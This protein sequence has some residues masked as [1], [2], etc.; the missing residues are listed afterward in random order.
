MVGKRLRGHCDS[1]SLHVRDLVDVSGQ[2]VDVNL[3]RNSRGRAGDVQDICKRQPSIVLRDISVIRVSTIPR[4][5]NRILRRGDRCLEG[6][7]WHVVF[8]V[9]FEE[10]TRR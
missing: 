5:T 8:N 1:L 7:I 9:C 3:V 10:M 4:S 2:P 6:D